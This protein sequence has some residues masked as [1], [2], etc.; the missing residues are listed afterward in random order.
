MD[1]HRFAGHHLA[2]HHLAGHHLAGT[3]VSRVFQSVSRAAW[4]RPF[5]QLDAMERPMR[6]FRQGHFDEFGW[7]RFFRGPA[8]WNADFIRYAHSRR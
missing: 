1:G 8:F 7:V 6:A 5:A 3:P 2:G 4:N